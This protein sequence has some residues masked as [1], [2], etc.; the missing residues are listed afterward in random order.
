MNWSFKMICQVRQFNYWKWLL[1]SV[2]IQNNTMSVIVIV[3][4]IERKCQIPICYSFV[5]M[6]VRVCVCVHKCNGERES[7]VCG[8]HCEGGL[9]RFWS[10]LLTWLYTVMCNE[11]VWRWELRRVCRFCLL[12]GLKSPCLK[13]NDLSDPRRAETMLSAVLGTISLDCSV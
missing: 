3:N 8:S 7:T 13:S 4:V 6:F 9:V 10:V 2:A 12:Q 5:R 11:V 1:H